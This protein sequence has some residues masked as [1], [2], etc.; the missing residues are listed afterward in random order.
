MAPR[1][2]LVTQRDVS[3]GTG[4]QVAYGTWSEA[5][6]VLIEA[7]DTDLVRLSM[8]IE[9]PRIRARR[10]LGRSWRQLRG[11]E[12]RLPGLFGPND[13]SRIL[14]GRYDVAIFLAFA[15][16]DLQLLERLQ[17]LR[18]HAD[19]VVVWFFETWPSSYHDGRVAHEPFH[20][21][22]D[23]F[24]ALE[25]AVEPLAET[26]GRDVTYLPM[27]TDTLRFSPER[28]DSDRPVDLIGIGRRRPEQHEAMLRWAAERDRFYLYDTTIIDRPRDYRRHRDMIG[29]WYAN[30]RL[31]VCNYGKSDQPEL[32]GDLRIIPGR[33]WESLASGAGMVGL[34]PSQDMQRLVLG[35]TV[36]EPMPTAADDLPIFLEEMAERHG[37]AEA[38]ANIRLALGAHDWAHRWVTLFNHL[39][40]EPPE[41]LQSR[42]A[43]LN[44][45]AEKFA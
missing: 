9:H 35:R 33:L 36:V 10:S 28:P 18:R 21:V 3:L 41:G 37:P 42:M 45:R 39:G 13:P 16:W 31:A 17:A 14:S 7:S 30:S 19:R 15:T 26:I 32:I 5:E 24:V 1:I 23:I 34:P 4:R 22:D 11:P 20:T 29:H 44:R 27:A 12:G 25:G 38:A 6:D 2:A 8:P 40:I 43:E